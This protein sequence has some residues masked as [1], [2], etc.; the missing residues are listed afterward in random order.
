MRQE[1]R[2][3]SVERAGT[4][5]LDLKVTH[6]VL[7]VVDLD[8]GEVHERVRVG[9]V[10]E[11]AEAGALHEARVPELGHL[12]RERTELVLHSHER[13][14]LGLVCVW[15]TG[16]RGSKNVRGCEYATRPVKH[17]RFAQR[18]TKP[19]SSCPPCSHAV[20]CP[21][22]TLNRRRPPPFA[23]QRAVLPRA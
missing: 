20:R 9:G 23:L 17:V 2:E 12:L 21:P 16:Q 19:G 11:L 8:V 18:C 6:V 15:G 5:E 13:L 4:H 14:D 1:P 10:D 7:V 3:K 22:R